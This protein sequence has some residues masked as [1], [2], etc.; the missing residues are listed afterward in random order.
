MNEHKLTTGQNL[1]GAL[2]NVCDFIALDSDM[3]EI[4]NAVEK[5]NAAK[6]K[7]VDFT[8]QEL[9]DISRYIHRDKK[10]TIVTTKRFKYLVEFQRKVLNR[11]KEIDFEKWQHNQ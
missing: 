10:E 8:L 4:V 9:S 3:T 1:F 2:R 6:F 7:E 11:L 5:D